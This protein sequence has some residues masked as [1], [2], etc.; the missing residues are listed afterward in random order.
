M[1]G[2]NT[3]LHFAAALGCKDI[4]SH[5]LVRGSDINGKNH[6]GATPLYLAVMNG[7][8]TVV[9]IL[10]SKKYECDLKLCDGKFQQSPL[11]VASLVPIETNGTNGFRKDWR[12]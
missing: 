4:V 11:H 6:E 9:D 1:D 2:G 7:H 5:L 8:H 12:I 10:L 3:L